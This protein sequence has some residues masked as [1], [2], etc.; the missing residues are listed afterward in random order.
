S[1]CPRTILLGDFNLP[2]IVWTSYSFPLNQPSSCLC[3]FLFN[4]GFHQIVNSPTR[5]MNILDLVFVS[6]PSSITDIS[7]YPPISSSDHNCIYLS[8]HLENN[9]CLSG[10]ANIGQAASYHVKPSY[11][12]CFRKGDWTSFNHYVNAVNW[13]SVF[14]NCTTVDEYWLEF[15]NVVSYGIN[16]FV[17][18]RQLRNSRQRKKNSTYPKSIRKLL[19]KKASAWRSLSRRKSATRKSKYKRLVVKCRSAI[20][21]FHKS[22][23]SKLIDGGNLG[24]FYKFVNSKVSSHPGVP[25]L[26][27]THGNTVTLDAEK[28]EL[29]NSFFS[30]VFTVD[31]HIIAP[32]SSS[33]PLS[34]SNQFSGVCSTPDLVLK[35]IHKLKNS[36]SCGVDLLPAYLYKQLAMSIAYPLNIIFNLSLSTSKLPADW[37]AAI[38]TPVFKKGLASDP[39]NYRPI[40]LTSTACKILESVIKDHI[41]AYLISNSLISPKQHGFLSR[42]ST[43]T[44]LLECC[45]IWHQ[46]L[47]S[48][49]QTDVIYLDLAKAFDSVVHS[50]LLYKLE[51]YGISGLA[52]NWIRDFLCNRTQCVKIGSALSSS[53]LVGSGVPQGSVLGPLLFLIFINDMC[54][55][56]CDGVDMRLFA[57]D[58]KLFHTISNLSSSA[59]LQSNLDNILKWC[60]DWQLQLS[61]SKCAVLSIGHRGFNYSYT[62]N[63]MPINRVDTIKDLGVTIDGSLSFD[64]HINNICAAARQRSGLILKCFSSRDPSLLIRAFCTYVRPLLEYASCI[65]SP[66]QKTVIHKIESVQRYFTK[67]LSYTTPLLYDSRLDFLG[68]DS[69]ELRRLKC[70]LTMY[71][72]ILH[73]MVDVDPKQ[74][75]SISNV[76][77]TRGHPLKLTKPICR[78]NTQLSNFNS[79]CINSWN[80]LPA[81]AVLTNSLRSFK[82]TLNTIR[83]N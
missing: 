63:N 37:K 15:H 12:Y 36:L 5:G 24:A 55:V 61:P 78:T 20:K 11:V 50:K 14:A 64:S 23:E 31:N 69:L 33:I 7:I 28:A 13:N 66:S 9:G 17:P 34:L 1:S 54:E 26:R 58:A 81:D 4:S 46:H 40:S 60:C 38:V 73:N 35:A 72:K 68:I 39:S 43:T 10:Q 29:L 42:R 45:D 19:N 6:D 75:F 22:R 80:Q 53:T 74:F 27:D 49:K 21:L 52:L 83:L 44:Q 3:E 76:N 16:L 48:K 2:G 70:D 77:Y 71:Y 62:I 82:T 59:T 18:R 8:L 67:R 47:S 25:P 51:Y 79:R 56:V 65:W 57:D 30:S 41:V 32:P